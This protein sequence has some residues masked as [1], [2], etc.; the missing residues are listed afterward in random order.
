MPAGCE[1]ALAPRVISG[2]DTLASLGGASRSPSVGVT[3]RGGSKTA[4]DN[5]ARGAGGGGELKAAPGCQGQ[6]GD[7]VR[8]AP[9]PRPT[10]ERVEWPPQVSSLSP[11][12]MGERSNSAAWACDTACLSERERG[13]AGDA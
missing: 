12:E 2:D 4:G 6:G 7:A 13:S 8:E 11:P 10:L 9:A 1:P 5:G 3:P